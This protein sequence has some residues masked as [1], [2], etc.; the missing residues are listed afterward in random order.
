MAI[1]PTW[2]RWPR[3]TGWFA[4]LGFLLVLLPSLLSHAQVSSQLTE[5]RFDIVGVKLAVSP[6]A[7][8]VPKNTPTYINTQLV[9]PE[10][11][12]A[13][14]ASVVQTIA[15]GASVEAELRGPSFPTTKITTQAGKPLQLPSFALPGD[16]F[17]DQIRLVKDG[18]AILEST[19]K[20][21]PIK[22]ISEVFVTSVSTRPLSLDEIRQKGIVIDEDN[23]QVQNF[24]IA[25]DFNNKAFQ[26][27]LPVVMPQM[28]GGLF[29]YDS[30]A[31]QQLITLNSALASTVQLP[32]ELDRPGLNFS[33]AAVPF[34]P[35]L[36]E[37]GDTAG[38]GIP[39][40]HGLVLIPGN[41]GFLNQFFSVLL[42]V[43][44]VSP[45]GS[46][47]Y[48]E[49]TEAEIT[50]PAGLDHVPGTYEHP[51]DDPLRLA[52][53]EGKGQVPIIAVVQ[54]GS[55]GELGTADDNPVIGPQEKGEGEFLVEGL[56]EGAH[57]L[58]IE[59]RAVLQGLPSGPVKL[60]GLAKGA[61]LVR[62]ADFSL[63]LSHPQTIRSGESYDLYTTLTNTSQTTANL[64]S[65]RLDPR[66]ISGARLVS[67]DS[68][69]F[70]TLPPGES[71]SAKFTLIAQKTGS[72]YASSFN[73]DPSLTGAFDLRTGIGERGIQLAPNAIALPKIVDKLP[74][75]LVAAAQR[76]L[77]QALSISTA[78]AGA[79]PSGVEF[80]KHQT[81]VT[82]GQELAE[83]GQRLAFGEPLSRVI[84]DLVLDWLGGSSFDEGF[85][86]IIHSTEAGAAFLQAVANIIGQEFEGTA[87]LEVQE[88]LA[89][90]TVPREP[91]IL[92]ITGLGAGAAPVVLTIRDSQGRTV[93]PRQ[94]QTGVPLPSGG[95]LNLQNEGGRVDLAAIAKLE[96]NSRYTVEVTG[97]GNG[98]FDLGIVVPNGSGQV[99]LLRYTNVA[100]RAGAKARVV[101]D[102]A[103]PGEYGMEVDLDGDGTVEETI[104]PASLEIHEEAPRVLAVRQLTQDDMVPT[105]F[106]PQLLEYGQYV[107]V[108]FDKPVTSESADSMSGKNPTASKNFAVEANS[109]IN[110]ALQQGRRLV[111]L[112]LQKPIGALVDRKITVSGIVDDRGM[113]LAS[114]T[115][116][117]QMMHSSGAR[118][119]GQVRTADGKP[120]PH[121][122]LELGFYPLD[123][124]LPLARLETD[125]E[126][127]FAV[128]FVRQQ[129]GGFESKPQRH[130]KVQH[131]D[132]GEF[133]DLEFYVRGAGETLFLTPTFVGKGTVRGRVLGTEGVTPV[134]DALVK[135]SSSQVFA[136]YNGASTITNALG[137]FVF[138]E[139]PVG[140]YTVMAMS[141]A[142]AYGQAA[143]VIES[144]GKES[145]VDIVVVVDQSLGRLTGRVF[146]SDGETPAEGFQVFVGRIGADSNGNPN[147]SAVA[148]TV[149]DSSGSFT[150]E[151]LP[152]GQGAYDVVAVD[153]ASRQVGRTNAQVSAG[154]TA[155][156]YVIMPA[157]GAVEGIVYNAQGRPVAGALVAGGVALGTADANGYFRIEGVPSGKT[158]IEAGDPVTKRRGSAQVNVLPGQTVNAAITLEARA[159][160]TGRILDANGNPKPQTTVR[161]VQGE[162]FLFV[163][164]NNSGIFRFP[165]LPLD[166]HLLEAPAPDG[167]AYLI[168][169]GLNP[170]I[171]YTAGDAPAKYNCDTGSP[172]LLDMTQDEILDLYKNAVET[173][174]G[175]NDP[176]IVGQPPAPEGGFGWNRV[177][178]YQDSVTVNADVRYLPQGTVSGTTLDSGGLPTGA[179]MRV[180]AIAPGDK[181]EPKFQ[182]LGGGN[183]NLQTGAFSYGGIAIFD[184]PTFQATGIRTGEFTLQAANP[185]SPVIVSHQGQLDTNNP[186]RSKIVLKFPAAAETNGTVSGQ[187][188][189]PDGVTPVGAGVQVHISF[190]DLTVTT[191]SEG[192][193]QS[194]FPIPAG[195]YTVT[196]EDPV[197]GLRGQAAVLVTAGGNGVVQG[198]L[199]GLGSVVVT[200]QRP[201]GSIVPNANV[202]LNR[203]TFPAERVDG[204]T[205]SMGTARFENISEGPFFVTATEQVTGLKGLAS[206]TIVRDSETSVVVTITASGVV[207]GTFISATDALPI[208]NARIALKSRSVE[209]TTT[210]DQEG[211]FR[212]D[213]I[214][215]GTFEV[216]GFDYLTGRAGRAFGEIRFQGDATDLTLVQLPMGSVQ[217]FVLQGDGS[218]PVL[219]ASITINCSAFIA[220]SLQATSRNDGSFRFDGV[221]AGD[222]DLTARD[223][224]TGFQGRASGTITSEGQLV[225][226]NII[227][228][229]FG[230][231][232]VKV[233]E[234]DGVT[235]VG[236]ASVTVKGGT[237]KYDSPV[238]PNG[239]VTFSPLALGQYDIVVRSLAEAHNGGTGTA[240][241]SMHGQTAEVTI[242]LRGI[243]DVEVTVLDADG[244]TPVPSAEV[245][246]N[247]Y[248]SSD[249]NSRGVFADNFVGYTNAS[250]V[251]RLHGVPLGDFSVMAKLPP[252]MGLSTGSITTPDQLVPITI[253]L[254][255]S[256]AI[257]GRVLLPDGIT[258]AA[259]ILVTL[260]FH[261]DGNR[262]PTTVQAATDLT[263][264]FTFSGIPYGS[265]EIFAYDLLT[266]GVGNLSGT[267]DA[268]DSNVDLGDLVLDNSPPR[269]VS[270]DPP[271]GSA[272]VPANA[273][274][275]LVFSEPMKPESF[276][277][278]AGS[279]S[280]KLA[281]IENVILLEGDRPVPAALSFS[282]DH[283]TFTMTPGELLQSSRLYTVTVKAA[284]LGPQDRVDFRPLDPFVS[285]FTVEDTIPPQ[286]VSASPANNERQVLP[287]A[288]VRI[289][290]SESVGSG[291]FLSLL[292]AGGALVAGRTD[293][294]LGNTVVIFT[295]YDYLVPNT[296]Y[297]IKL[298]NVT[299]LA[300]NPLEGLPFTSRFFTV[301]TIPPVI[302]SLQ[303]Q[304]SLIAGTNAIVQPNITGTD[305]A[306]VEYLIGGQTPQVIRTS[307]FAATVTLP[308]GV[309]SIQVTAVAVDASGNRSQSVTV[310]IVIGANQAPAVTLSPPAGLSSLVQGQK[311]TFA[312]SAT[313][314]V[315]LT[316]IIFSVNGA[317]SQ[318]RVVSV[319][320]GTVFNAS[321][322]VVVPAS[323]ASGSQVTVQ[324]VARDSANNL[325]A[326]S[327]LTYT[328]ADTIKPA[329]AFTSPV[330]RAV[331][332]PGQSV[333][334]V[335]E[336]ADDV[337]LS[338]INLTCS[339]GLSGCG[340]RSFNPAVTRGTGTYT[341]YV[342]ETVAAPASMVLSASAEDTSG[343]LNLTAVRTLV[344]ADN[345]TPQMAGLH[346]LSG[347]SRVA[348][349]QSVRVRAE[350][351]DNVGISAIRFRCQGASTQQQTV[352]INPAATSAA[353]EFEVPVPASAQNGSTLSVFALAM[354][355]AGNTSSELSLTLL[356]GD[357]EPPAVIIL[358][359]SDGVLVS[360][361]ENLTLA[362][363]A[364][365]DV[366]IS[367]ISYAA[368]GVVSSGGIKAIVPASTPVQ[369]TFDLS[370]PQGTNPGVVLLTVVAEDPAGNQSAPAQRQVVV[371]DVTAPSVQITSPTA[372][373]EIDPR[374]PLNVTVVASDDSGVAEVVFDAQGVASSHQVRS[375]APPLAGTS[376]IFSVSFDSQLPL[377]GSI[378]VNANAKDASGNV[379]NASP[380][381]LVVRDVV[382]PRVTGVTPTNGA[383]N[384][385]PNA[386]IVVQFSEPLNT[387]TVT[388][389][390][391]SLSA[392][393]QAVPVRHA[394]SDGGQVVNITPITQPLATNTDFTL[395]VSTGVSDRSGNPL[396]STFRS[397]FRT[398]SPDTVGP[399]VISF[400][401]A[402]GA[403]D[404]SVSTNITATFSE[405]IDPA[406]I[407]SSSF[408]TS[409]SGSPLPGKFDF[410][411]G[412]TIVQFNPGVLPLKTLVSVQLSN[413]IKDVAGNPLVDSSGNPLT[414]P[415]TYTFTTGEFSISNPKNGSSVTEKNPLT[416]TAQASSALGIA[417]VVFSVNGQ[418]L[419]AVNA[420]PP[421]N[422]R[423]QVPDL[424]T[425][426][427]LTI[428]ASAR[429]SGGNEIA[430]DE[431]SVTVTTGVELKPRILGVP[432]NGSS[433]LRLVLSSP[434]SS[435]LTVDMR[436]VD[437]G[438][439]YVPPQVV[440]LAG[441]LEATVEISGLAVGS[442]TILAESVL[443]VS[444]GILS[445]SEKVLGQTVELSASPV[446]LVSPPSAAEISLPSIPQKTGFSI[447]L[448]LL[449][450]PAA[451]D[452]PVSV[453][454]SDPSV[455]EVIGSAVIPAG[456]TS[457]VLNLLAHKSGT[458]VLTLRF[459]NTVLRYTIYV[460]TSA[461]GSVPPVLARP[462]GFA[463]TITST[464][465]QLTMPP[466]TSNTVTMQLLDS[467]AASDIPV[468]ASSSDPSVVE[469]GGSALIAAG[470]QGTTLQLTARQA[471]SAVITL[472]FGASVFQF[473]VNVGTAQPG[474]TPPIVA[475]PVGVS[476][477]HESSLGLLLLPAAGLHTVTL[478]L[479][480]SP[481]GSDTPVTVIS[482]DPL[483]VEVEGLTVIRAGEQTA[484]LILAAGDNGCSML[485]LQTG[486]V[487]RQI[488]ICVGGSTAGKDVPV[489]A[490]P[491][492]LDLVD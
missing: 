108:L 47:L 177:R 72:V 394:V 469:V 389:S 382:P 260:K 479:V 293:F 24:Q 286:V 237:K 317:M 231:I 249:V 298:D 333:D 271:A 73:R 100:T 89:R 291:L 296:A 11:A 217:G 191:D 318:S 185:F 270:M 120:V 239:E 27:D 326:P 106:V 69:T 475:K 113:N 150:F 441:E 273:Q 119:L 58:D 262:P 454:S 491:V 416:I 142:G 153:R 435:A 133:A 452:I 433:T 363:Q 315:G 372:G 44:N 30:E 463:S 41:V 226:R 309:L 163:V 460:G 281:G 1:R 195:S 423:Y 175:L 321:F 387:S 373:A 219:G 172:A 238:N 104:S 210:T 411:A 400:S 348:P 487:A 345:I 79:L 369:A 350:G 60:K 198:R 45:D 316:E 393:G 257:S 458:A 14:A 450:E 330:N 429:D 420:P 439:A 97:T 4:G 258:P 365:D 424:E 403:S 168:D 3:S 170:C 455:L 417:N 162:G 397:T 401:P 311:V 12:G 256:G 253:Q 149:T 310:P 264:R 346:S 77:G 15:A 398:A 462:V 277:P 189:M 56:R 186:N 228:E 241:I 182:N 438:V 176:L 358:S 492:G 428:T 456:G 414:A 275:R 461:S 140:P 35:V 65:V 338:A 37:G 151:N 135:L 252:L 51:G 61:V 6:S 112:F 440:I 31:G 146:L 203:A 33:V 25:F 360:P 169:K 204:V 474:T 129:L 314:D 391:V 63:T 19:P 86:Q 386:S 193:F 431:V 161:I 110:S 166:D 251:T 183:S 234:P 40:I 181:G 490:P 42:M 471:G 141:S 468:A 20:V 184:L 402:N 105:R 247:A 436:L 299:D 124:Y 209:V 243:G 192:R 199:L 17:L 178:L 179:A 412:N 102:L 81:V 115:L 343:N 470:S 218:T 59:I 447:S 240:S 288:L 16:Y 302:T 180:Q 220:Y 285:S 290:F 483:V 145:V 263:G 331:V 320:G 111:Y 482:S 215:V 36:D 425:A 68:V 38:F 443:G 367:R 349:G 457:I 134:R 75:P 50:L 188:F 101:I 292:D 383:T 233:F 155:T 196:V 144:A 399:R 344:A 10:G 66:S 54:R 388:G 138:T 32:P 406:T 274:I 481:V 269:V 413:S 284:P 74:A 122:V 322:D 221:P 114:A 409:A 476:L 214:P 157:L 174:I 194:L 371:R 116:P 201:D 301:D 434:Q 368:S 426:S 200:V 444:G 139:V 305:V 370:I 49:D 466:G 451:S 80:V 9:L 85:D 84:A 248:A 48:L 207:T 39:P 430:R 418:D 23:F 43:T 250:G 230:A 295:P 82:R 307:P 480:D 2:K 154:M 70:E 244:V 419:P 107:G 355:A 118:V 94:M 464:S 91:H 125:A 385:D 171:A 319:P 375:I 224:S 98:L 143:G 202:E 88:S 212:F 254:E 453:E 28:A 427:S 337:G 384:V 276:Y 103:N 279:P 87:W 78:P 22:V 117:I 437:P 222:F 229:G 336:A 323:A 29:R 334:V 449:D 53:I 392:A 232:H 278:Y 303:L 395:T 415:L 407:S 485:R 467:P 465:L 236:N 410:L 64:V 156:T 442:T 159:T 325:S 190:G 335:V 408:Q 380:L 123:V 304:G 93:A 280:G 211:R 26:I 376:Q 164:S 308:V 8:T 289:T 245:N 223:P 448:Q 362:V 136:S 473:T 152:P 356:V 52:R 18:K 7:L 46:T 131:P 351:M 213:A 90:T 488:E 405:P 76:V 265:F 446:G 328:L 235:T 381:T 128:D 404:V 259:Q 96:S 205:D 341:V 377:G 95:L 227:L 294:T 67:E 287:E 242:T 147:I 347:S 266:N 268:G 339:Q 92:A 57:D 477:P 272:N 261:P 327:T 332:I 71:T 83:A 329:V 267:L 55:D 352:P 378:T 396:E 132:T 379:G 359:P 432:L 282:D 34:W 255:P 121:S 225:E 99:Q 300:G 364:T 13:D 478:E 21:V 126:G 361:G 5:L 306:R 62:N 246:V 187:V 165:D 313:D 421:F 486:S 445:V 390:T 148:Q 158:A 137:E 208:P 357:L 374:T 312:A 109:T 197:S 160:I 484:E 173:F 216:R 206:G 353:A 366:A 354:D 459:Q 324:A 283:Q 340:T 130:F 472:K 297:Q 167:A 342:P 422:T 489:L 127:K